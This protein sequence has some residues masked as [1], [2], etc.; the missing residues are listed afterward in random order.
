MYQGDQPDALEQK[1]FSGRASVLASRLGV[2]FSRDSTLLLFMRSHPAI[3]VDPGF[4]EMGASHMQQ[5][6]KKTLFL[7]VLAVLYGL[8]PGHAALAA[9][10]PNIVFILADDLGYGD[11]R[12]QTTSRCQ[13]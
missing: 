3:G 7:V 1:A 4:C 13:A 10:K 5:H 12:C 9:S 2:T 6:S 8:A 11:V